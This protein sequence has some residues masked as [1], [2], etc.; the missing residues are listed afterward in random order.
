M[1]ANILKRTIE[2]AVIEHM[3]QEG[4]GLYVPV[5]I[6]NRHVHLCEADIE[7]LFGKGYALKKV[8]ELSQPGQYVCGE[9]LS[10]LGPKGTV[11]KIRVLGPARAETQVEISQTDTYIAG[12]KPY[13]RMSGDLQGTPGGTLAGPAGMVNLE[14]GV[15]V[16]ARHLHLSP[17]EAA[18]YGIKKGDIV[19]VKKSGV[20]EV[21]FGN[22]SV[23]T[24]E[25]HS[26]EM[27][28]DTDEANAAGMKC[29]ELLELIKK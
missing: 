5:A 7:V 4:L 15:I 21:I 23:R 22:V 13:V 3:A 18:L 1:Q 26:L 12:I 24:G 16:S 27:H 10:F 11:H 20:R 19:S 6:S 9:T 25:G 14:S 28:I 17:A 2:L 29:G 8:R